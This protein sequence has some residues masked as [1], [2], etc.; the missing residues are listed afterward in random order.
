M[1]QSIQADRLVSV[2]TVTAVVT[3]C[4][5]PFQILVTSVGP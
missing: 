1:K 5:G 4:A 2:V 3:A